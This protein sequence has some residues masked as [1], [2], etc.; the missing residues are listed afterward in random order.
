MPT[1]SN[2]FVAT[3]KSES[4]GEVSDSYP[5]MEQANRWLDNKKSAENIVD[6][7]IHTFP[8]FRT[9]QYYRKHGE[10]YHQ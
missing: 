9:A 1:Q 4:W 6:S 7:A 3:W 10:Y 8:N 5:H 2:W